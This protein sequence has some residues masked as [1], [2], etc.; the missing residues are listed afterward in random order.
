MLTYLIPQKIWLFLYV[1]NKYTQ[2]VNNEV[3]PLMFLSANH[4][5]SYMLYCHICSHVHVNNDTLL[6]FFSIVMDLTPKFKLSAFL[7]SLAGG[8]EG[9]KS[10]GE[11]PG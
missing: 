3:N 1:V 8:L 11:I 10:R 6:C 2:L 9:M 4:F 5:I 7:V